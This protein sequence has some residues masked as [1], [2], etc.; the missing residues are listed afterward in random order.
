M[1][2]AVVAI[3]WWWSRIRA[4]GKMPGRVALFFPPFSPRLAT[5]IFDTADVRSGLHLSRSVLSDPSPSPER[6]RATNARKKSAHPA[7]MR[8]LYRSARS[9]WLTT[10][11]SCEFCAFDRF[12]SISFFIS[13]RSAAR[14]RVSIRELFL[15]CFRNFH[16]KSASFPTG[17]ADSFISPIYWSF[18]GFDPPSEKVL[19]IAGANCAVVARKWDIGLDT[20][21]QLQGERKPGLD[22]GIA[23]SSETPRAELLH[24]QADLNNHLFWL[25]MSID[26]GKIRRYD[27]ETCLPIILQLYVSTRW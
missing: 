22:T 4:K 5:G 13:S 17:R 8:H 19:R 10:I 15:R 18:S 6:P 21:E 9:V 23:C 1:A 26:R 27:R 7:K 25:L 24:R 11:V 16:W 2:A 14:I 20:T 12:F 3:A